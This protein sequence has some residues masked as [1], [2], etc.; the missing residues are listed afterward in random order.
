MRYR[1]SDKSQERLNTCDERLRRICEEA[2]HVSPIDFTVLCGHRT[3]LQQMI[4]YQEN[5]SKVQW[6]DSK[7]NPKPSL[8][9]DLVP[10]PL[11]WKDLNRF[12]MLA[13]VILTVANQLDIPLE[14]GGNWKTFKDYPHYQLKEG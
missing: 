7:H 11:D 9:V 3:E 6:P 8:A 10:H 13:G 4:A 14:W 2:I 1:F 12:S 5:K